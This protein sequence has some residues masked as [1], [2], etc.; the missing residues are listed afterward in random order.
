MVEARAYG[1]KGSKGDGACQDRTLLGKLGTFSRFLRN[2][3]QNS[4]EETVEQLLE[5]GGS[6]QKSNLYKSSCS[7]TTRTI[8]IG[9]RSF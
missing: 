5:H 6:T 8:F 7:L 3:K 1:S 2:L 4:G 9:V